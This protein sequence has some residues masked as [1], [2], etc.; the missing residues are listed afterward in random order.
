MCRREV[1]YKIEWDSCSNGSLRRWSIIDRREVNGADYLNELD[2][3]FV[4]CFLK[5]IS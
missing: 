4:N 2:E 3:I 1:N 5:L